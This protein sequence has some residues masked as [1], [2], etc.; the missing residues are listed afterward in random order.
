M[1]AADGLTDGADEHGYGLA[2]ACL[3]S[4]GDQAPSPSSNCRALRAPPVYLSTSRQ[5]GNEQMLGS[6]N[7]APQRPVA[8][9]RAPLRG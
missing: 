4:G 7:T 9:D 1:L 3:K 2:R 5:S 8:V 6:E